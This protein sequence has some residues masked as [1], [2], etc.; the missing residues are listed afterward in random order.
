MTGITNMT[1]RFS[2]FQP[3]IEPK[4]VIFRVFGKTCEGTFIDRNDETQVYIEVSKQ[5]L[6]PEL[7]GYDEQVR[8][9][10]FL[11]STVLNSKVKQ[12]VEV[13]IP[14]TNCL[15]HFY[16]GIWSLYMSKDPNID[17]DYIDFANERFQKYIESRK[18]I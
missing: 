2:H 5:G 14:L 12:M 13:E 1:F 18:N 15:A 3:E 9:E 16:W 11:Y 4:D 10:K 8:A 17:F 6:G 7:Y